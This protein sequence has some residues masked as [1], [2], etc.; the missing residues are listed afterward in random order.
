MTRETLL[1][2]LLSYDPRDERELSSLQRFI[3][4]VEK[5]PGCFDRELPASAEPLEISNIGH[6]TGSAWLLNPGRSA[7]LFTHHKKLGKWLQPGG[8]ADGD[9]DVLRVAVREA[10][11]ESGIEKIEPISQEIFDL[12][13]HAIPEHKGITAHY[14]YDIRYALQV[15]GDAAFKISDESIDLA[16]VAINEIPNY[17][18]E[19]SLLRMQRKWL[20]RP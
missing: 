13:V 9:P 20:A 1:K 16:W 14:H 18:R 17:S 6:I 12:D 10:R 2:S 19:E 15:T 5:N 7:V 8:H 4:F 3:A 11:E